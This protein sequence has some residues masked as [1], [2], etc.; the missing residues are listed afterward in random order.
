[1]EALKKKTAYIN[2]LQTLLRARTVPLEGAS[3][4]SE[5]MAVASEAKQDTTLFIVLSMIRGSTIDDN[6]DGIVALANKITA[7]EGYSPS[8]QAVCRAMDELW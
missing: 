6:S 7:E 8:F 1:M 2:T 5:L 3:T 4:L